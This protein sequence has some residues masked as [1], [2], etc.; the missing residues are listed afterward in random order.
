MDRL[1]IYVIVSFQRPTVIFRVR[2][3]VN[4]GDGS[5]SEAIDLPG[6]AWDTF[7]I[8]AADVN[9]DGHVDIIVGNFGSGQNNQLLL[10]A[11]EYIYFPAR[12]CNYYRQGSCEEGKTFNDVWQDC[13]NDGPST[14]MGIMW[15][16][17]DNSYPSLS[18][19]KGTGE[20]KLIQAGTEVLQCDQNEDWGAYVLKDSCSTC[21]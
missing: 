16:P 7:S 2:V 5:Y 15:N 8:A 10:H 12:D 13:L 18:N 20:W 6:G 17:C 1:Y 9:G 14:C 4:N 21:V 11:G 3:R 19:I